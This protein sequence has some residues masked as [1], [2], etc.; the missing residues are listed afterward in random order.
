MSYAFPLAA[1]ARAALSGEARAARTR[2]EA[3]ALAGRETLAG[4]DAEWLTLS[5]ED[6]EALRAAIEAGVE[7]GFV[8]RY[9]DARGHTVLAVTFWRLATGPSPADPAAAAEPAGEDDTDD[10]YFKRGRTKRRARRR[11][12]D[13]SQLDLFAGPDEAGQGTARSDASDDGTTQGG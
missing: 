8:Q 13:R 1:H 3:R 11:E 9:E 6:A 5:R 12:P 4:L 7:Q 10:L 2:A